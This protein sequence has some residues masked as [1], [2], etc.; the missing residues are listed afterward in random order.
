MLG[1][2]VNHYQAPDAPGCD[3]ADLLAAVHDV[4]GV[5]RIR[6][7][8][9]HPRHTG[10]RLIEA[11][12]DLPR[13]CKHMHLPVQSG[14]TRV[15]T[16]MRRRY[17]RDEY[18]DL[19]APHPRGDPGRD[20]LD[21]HDRRLS[22]RDGGRLRPDAVADRARAVPQHVLVQV[23]RAAE[24]AGVEADA[25][26]GRRRRED[27]AHRGAAVAAAGHPDAAARAGAWAPASKCS[28]IHRVGGGTAR[29]PAGRREHCRE[30][31]RSDRYTQSWREPGAPKPQSGEGGWMGRTVPVRIT[32][33]GPHS[34]WGEMQ[35]DATARAGAGTDPA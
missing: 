7:A 8:S 10:A 16:A 33:S 26:H 1:Q 32:R 2:I 15:L 12:R 11:M 25:R 24:H 22:R 14:S 35:V 21:G 17:S 4:P 34:L 9:P 19:V 30:P 6:F 3:F 18:L 13:V 5:E 20:P 28:S 31:C 23:L 29:F 27:G